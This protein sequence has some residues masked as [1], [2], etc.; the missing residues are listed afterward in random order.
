MSLTE[1]KIYFL[2]SFEFMDDG[3][4]KL[5]FKSKRIK[6]KKKSPRVRKQASSVDFFPSQ[7]LFWVD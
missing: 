6:K 5:D 1:F 4:P 7:V 2:F 3:D